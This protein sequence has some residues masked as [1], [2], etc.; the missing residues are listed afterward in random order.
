MKV[1][2]KV[3]S[4]TFYLFLDTFVVTFL[5]FVY[6]VLIGKA[7]RPEDLGIIATSTIL[8]SFLSALALLGLNS[9][10]G[11]LIPEYA[12]RDDK[13]RISGL[14]KFSF[15]FTL[16]T[17]IFL[18]LILAIFSFQICNL[19][20]LPL[21]VFYITIIGIFVSSFA[22][23]A[24]NI[25]YGLQ[26]MK[27]YFLI[28]LAGNIVKL[29][30][31]GLIIFIGFSFYG[32]LMGFVF[33]FLLMFILRLEKKWFFIK[34]DKIDKKEVLIKYSFPSLIYSLATYVF[35][36]LQFII[37]P[38]MTTQHETGLFAL[39]NKYT[40]PL[41][42]LAGTLA[43]ALLPTISGLSVYQEAM[44]KKQAK[45][46]NL[47]LRY[48]LLLTLP[49]LI[50]FVVFSKAIILTFASSQYL[51][52]FHLFLPLALSSV[53]Y[54]VSSIF[55]NSLYA[56]RKPNVMRNISILVATI[57]LIS[58]IPL[59]IYFSSLG[60]SY[61]VLIS[62]TL[63]L[64]LGFVELRRFLKISIDTKNLLKLVLANLVFLALMLI[65]DVIPYNL[66]IKIILAAASGFVYLFML[67]FLRFYVKEDV[68]V[69]FYI[70]KKLPILKNQINSL[71][72]MI[73]KY[74]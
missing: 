48:S 56:I 50:F 8:M 15:K 42:V 30:V 2:E 1:E 63:M 9:A 66:M 39:A 3:I 12:E 29:V 25:I 67:L 60:M 13:K 6:W 45:I 31:S 16:I 28:D 33:S 20:K 59:T 55:I 7:L 64:I 26:K 52:A 41:S 49:V 57:F 34:S 27:K 35:T 71:A 17:N 21:A 22:A 10:I 65:I 14:V 37:L 62:M 32:P 46:I 23:I 69:A 4:N 51:D 61:A 74:V 38:I 70:A 18:A 36:S 11:K 43:S 44:K 53:F 24:G 73:S 54:G 40:F 5:S 72:K 47:G 19:L 68:T 58:S